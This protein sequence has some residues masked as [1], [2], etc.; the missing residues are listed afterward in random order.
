MGERL[1]PEEEEL[2]KKMLEERGNRGAV[3]FGRYLALKGLITEED[4]CNARR[5][6]KNQNRMIGE[7]AVDRGF[8]SEEDVEN[9]LIFQEET[10]ILFGELAINFGYLTREQVDELLD[11]LDRAYIFFG[12]A[13]VALRV[14]GEPEMLSNLST[15]QRMKLGEQEYNA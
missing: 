3:L 4:I 15:F 7:V 14:L 2:F 6:Q 11:H 13:L 10:G 8:L 1:I 9:L 12:E 5:F